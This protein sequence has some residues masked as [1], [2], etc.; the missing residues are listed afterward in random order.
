[1]HNRIVDAVGSVVPVHQIMS[2]DEMTCRL[3][4]EDRD[5]QKAAA[6]GIQI[7]SAIRKRAGDSLTCSI[8]IAPNTMLAKVAADMKKPDG[9][10]VFSDSDLPQ[11]YMA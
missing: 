1:M 8:G 6:L 11:A 2:I 4:G 7:K 9:L 3:M 5:S 10:T